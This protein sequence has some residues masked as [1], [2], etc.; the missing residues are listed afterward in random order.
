MNPSKTAKNNQKSSLFFAG[1][2][3]SLQLLIIGGKSSIVG[4]SDKIEIIDIDNGTHH[5][6]NSTPLLPTPMTTGLP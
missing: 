2:G 4:Y 3:N 6:L 1:W 5:C